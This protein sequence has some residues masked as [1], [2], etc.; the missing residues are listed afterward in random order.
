MLLR[1]EK[2]RE[3]MKGLSKGLKS[4]ITKNMTLTYLASYRQFLEKSIQQYPDITVPE[5]IDQISMTL[6]KEGYVPPA[7]SE[8]E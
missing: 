3:S 2:A 4:K 6:D 7:E 1:A 5:L 8:V